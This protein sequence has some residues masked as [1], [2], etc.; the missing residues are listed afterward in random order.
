VIVATFATDGPEQCS[1]LVV[2]WYKRAQ[3]HAEFGLAFEL[4][5]PASEERKTP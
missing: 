5:E 1:G 2:A 4:L 3:L